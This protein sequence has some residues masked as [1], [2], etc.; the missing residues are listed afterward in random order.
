MIKVAFFTV[1]TTI[2]NMASPPPGM[3]AT[4]TLQFEG[5]DALPM[6][7]DY[8]RGQHAGLPTKLIGNRSVS[9]DGRLRR[10]TSCVIISKE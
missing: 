4:G 9:E 3:V 1:L 10:E 5:P 8:A 7:Q 6:C 2:G